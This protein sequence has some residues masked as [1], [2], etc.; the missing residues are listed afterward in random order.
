MENKE[1]AQK[2]VL[3]LIQGGVIKFPEISISAEASPQNLEQM[4]KKAQA[5]RALV[6]VAAQ[7]LEDADKR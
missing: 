5:V 7:A 2:L 6:E 1:F 4:R 3:A